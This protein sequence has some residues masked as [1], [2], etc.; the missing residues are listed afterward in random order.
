MIRFA[1]AMRNE[2]VEEVVTD[3]VSEND[4]KPDAA[5]LSGDRTNRQG[6]ERGKK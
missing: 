6:S 5:F 3:P 1:H 4:A 2:H